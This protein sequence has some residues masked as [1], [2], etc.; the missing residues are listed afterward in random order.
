MT[1]AQRHHGE[2]KAILAKRRELYKKSQKI[3]PNRWSNGT[4]N[5]D[6][7]GDVELNPE[8]EKEAA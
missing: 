3:T 4:R 8:N 5:W 1:P 2:D 7:I 6:E